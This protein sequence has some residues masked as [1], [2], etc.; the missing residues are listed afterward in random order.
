[1][2]LGVHAEAVAPERGLGRPRLDPAQVDPAHRELLEDRQEG[3]RLVVGDVGDE[4]RLVGS[5]RRGPVPG[6]GDEDEAG[7]C[8]VVVG[9][10]GGERHQAVHLAGDGRADGGVE[11]GVGVGDG[12]GGAGGRAALDDLG[13]RQVLREPV[14]HLGG[15]MRV[16]DDPADPVDAR[17]GTRA[18]G[19]AHAHEHLVE[20]PQRL[21][22]RVGQVV[23]GG[24]DAALD[25]VLDRHH[26]GLDP[27]GAHGVEGLGDGAEGDRLGRVVRQQGLVREGARR[28]EV[29]EHA[30]EPRRWAA[31]APAVSA[32]A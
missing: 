23:E 20:D 18:Q 22:P 29:S 13:A 9:D 27:A 19:E 2:A 4:R 11:A 26:D 1:M 21:G 10:V 3:A 5:G 31:P 8:R 16:G 28:A 25:G 30:H 32:R 12:P 15:G 17:A 7:D 14:A 6:S 24:R